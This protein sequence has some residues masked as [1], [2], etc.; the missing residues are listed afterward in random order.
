MGRAPEI[1]E[2]FFRRYAGSGEPYWRN[3]LLYSHPEDCVAWVLEQ[4]PGAVRSV[5]VLGA[6]TGQVLRYLDRRLGVKP[7]G[8]EVSRWAWE[9]IPPEYR[10][11]VRCASMT[12]EVRRWIARRRVF[13]L[14]YSNSLIYLDRDEL[15]DFLP[16]L[17][18]AARHLYF[19]SSVRGACC[20]DPH[21]KTL[22]SWAWW[23]RQLEAAGFDHLPPRPGKRRGYVWR[24][25]R[26][27]A[28]P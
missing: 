23:E 27:A 25:A 8:C 21:R 7:W 24:S 26:V 20:P 6:A 19:R 15:A 3:W 12:D 4:P 1:D 5:W 22:E 11:R 17:V 2:G 16:R 18:L 9:R 13:D 14:A 10:R 28:P